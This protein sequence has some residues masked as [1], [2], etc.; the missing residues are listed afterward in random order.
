MPVGSSS[1]TDYT[2]GP[3]EIGV[4][5]V[6]TSN[7]QIIKQ[8]Y[9]AYG[10][11]TYQ[12]TATLP[13]G[14]PP[15]SYALTV[16]I[17][18]DGVINQSNGPTSGEVVAFSGFAALVPAGWTCIPSDY[19]A[20]DGCDCACG[21][22]DPDCTPTSVVARG[23]GDANSC[24]DD[25]CSGSALC[26]YAANTISCED[27]LFCTVNDRCAAGTC[28]TS[29]ARDCSP[30]PNACNDAYCNE[31]QRACAKTP[32]NEGGGCVCA[33]G[34][35]RDCTAQDDSCS[36]GVCDAQSGKCGQVPKPNGIACND[37]SACTGTPLDCSSLAD[38]S[39]SARPKQRERELDF[40]EGLSANLRGSIPG[41]DDPI[42]QPIE[43]KHFECRQ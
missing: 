3:S 36:V 26:V 7:C 1:R 34:K 16:E 35:S 25:R 15:G 5:A 29:V 19:N 31:A 37:L 14:I 21:T 43:A 42:G 32:K 9:P 28:A 10:Q 17:D 38:S 20:L 39:V 22:P 2:W 24:T 23:C 11:D 4:T 30:A 13:A 6:W 27:G 18:P 33:S 40:V 41:S 8:T 12:F